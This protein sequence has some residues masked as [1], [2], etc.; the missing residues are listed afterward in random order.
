MRLCARDLVTKSFVQFHVTREGPSASYLDSAPVEP[1]RNRLKKKHHSPCY[2]SPT[3]L[4]KDCN[5]T[6]IESVRPPLV[7]RTSDCSLSSQG[8]DGATTPHDTLYLMHCFRVSSRRWIKDSKKVS[9][10]LDHDGVNE[11]R[12]RKLG[13]T[14]AAIPRSGFSARITPVHTYLGS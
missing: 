13:F 11:G 6:H 10:S 4:T 2:S 14:D 7:A 8:E 1:K 9:I 5:S 12:L 3:V